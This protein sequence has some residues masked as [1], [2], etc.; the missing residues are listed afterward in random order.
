[1]NVTVASQAF[2][3]LF[4]DILFGQVIAGGWLSA[5]VTVTVKEQLAVILATSVTVYIKVVMPCGK[6]LPLF[7]PVLSVC[8]VVAPGQLSVPTGG[9]Y[10]TTNAS[11]LPIEIFAGQVIL[12]GVFSNVVVIMMTLSHPVTSVKTNDVT[13]T[14]AGKQVTALT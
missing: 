7:R 14:S 10:V 5:I 9:T 12:G 6:I 2:G 8:R 13:P 1:M 4:T 3:E 11:Q